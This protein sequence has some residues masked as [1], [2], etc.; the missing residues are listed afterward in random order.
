MYS[1]APEDHIVL[2]ATKCQKVPVKLSIP[3]FEN[4]GNPHRPSPERVGKLHDKKMSTVCQSNSGLD[5]FDWLTEFIGE[6]LDNLAN[7]TPCVENHE[8]KRRK[9]DD[10][11]E[12]ATI[13]FICTPLLVN[14]PTKQATSLS[15]VRFVTT[16]SLR[17]SLPR[18]EKLRASVYDF[19]EMK[20]F[21]DNANIELEKLFL[22]RD[23]GLIPIPS[24]ILGNSLPSQTALSMA[25]KIDFVEN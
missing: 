11:E 25:E 17:N 6:Q 13:N 20:A 4:E 24:E 23:S 3:V 12:N 14:V 10:A 18:H 9:T 5:T 21:L 16:D 15:S 1:A 22:P 8:T 2:D 7:F 19:G